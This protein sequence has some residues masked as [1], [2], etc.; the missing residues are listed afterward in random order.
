MVP[1]TALVADRTDRYGAGILH[2]SPSSSGACRCDS[3]V[4]IVPKQGFF[5]GNTLHANVGRGVLYTTLHEAEGV[6][7][8]KVHAYKYQGH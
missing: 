7:R 6:A 2:S 1:C 8:G 5:A 3:M 4:T